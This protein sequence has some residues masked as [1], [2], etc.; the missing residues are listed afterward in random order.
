MNET[1]TAVAEVEK[2]FK[3]GIEWLDELIEHLKFVIS[4][5]LLKLGIK[6]MF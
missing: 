1:T 4:K 2:D 3:T 5:L 6:I